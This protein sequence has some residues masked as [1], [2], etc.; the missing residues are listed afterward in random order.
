[1]RRSTFH[2]S[3][4][5]LVQNKGL[6]IGLDKSKDTSISKLDNLQKPT[7]AVQTSN[8]DSIY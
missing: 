8:L 4:S 6:A 3:N 7:L 2:G 5:V 1:M